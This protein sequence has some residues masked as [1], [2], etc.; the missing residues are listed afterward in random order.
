MVNVKTTILRYESSNLGQKN[1][2]S[3]NEEE[4]KVLSYEAS[5]VAKEEYYLKRSRT[6]YRVSVCIHMGTSLHGL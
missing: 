2:P 6:I 1:R 4:K 3:V 5:I